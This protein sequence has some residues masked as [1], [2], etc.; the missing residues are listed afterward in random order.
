MGPSDQDDN[1]DSF[2]VSMTDIMVGLLFI[3]ILIIMYF[4]I[5]SKLDQEVMGDQAGMLEEATSQRFEAVENSTWLQVQL[6]EAT[7]ELERLQGL[8]RQAAVVARPATVQTTLTKYQTHV[9]RQRTKLLRWLEAYLLEKGVKGVELIEEQGV[10]RLPEGIL[11]RSSEFR[12]KPEST[13]EFASQT[14]ASA[15]A[16][17]LPCSV[18]N[19]EGKP[20]KSLNSC[21]AEF[22]HN[23]NRAFVQGVYVEGHTDVDEI[24]SGGLPGDRNLTTNLKLSARRSTNTFE[25]I[26]RYQPVT[27]EFYGPVFGL[28]ELRFEPILASAAYGQWRPINLKDTEEAKRGNRRIDLRIVMYQPLNSGA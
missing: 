4:A 15:L 5:Q 3:F 27:M 26:T 6:N 1:E 10:L 17:V 12:I 16:A 7:K 20:F 21:P 2:F 9:R 8:H 14:L 28:E 11:F 24:S 18:L 22:Y 13:A 19:K 25:A 23:E